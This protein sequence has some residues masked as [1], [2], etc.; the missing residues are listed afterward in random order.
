M[1]ADRV[2]GELRQIKIDIQN[3]FTGRNDSPDADAAKAYRNAE[4]LI[5]KFQERYGY[6]PDKRELDQ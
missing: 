1:N 6:I 2:V 4:E 3:W 5:W